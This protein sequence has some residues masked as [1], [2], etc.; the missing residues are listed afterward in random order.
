MCCENA[1]V[2]QIGSD[3]SRQDQRAFMKKM[4]LELD[5]KSWQRFDKIRTGLGV[6]ITG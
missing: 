3:W 6:F 5:F 2:G 1:K 4:A